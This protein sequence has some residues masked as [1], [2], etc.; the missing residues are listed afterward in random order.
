MP[1]GGATRHS[2]FAGNE[3]GRDVPK[4]RH[5]RKK[6]SILIKK[7]FEASPT[8]WKP[9]FVRL[10]VAWLLSPCLTIAARSSIQWP[11]SNS[12]GVFL[13][14]PSTIT[15]KLVVSTR[16]VIRPTTLSLSRD[17]PEML[18]KRHPLSLERKILSDSDK[19]YVRVDL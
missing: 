9:N 13:T 1:F 14:A 19:P 10:V 16:I 3:A 11:F 18:S 8:L 12:P 17:E 5:V 4:V 2:H 7:A 15:I 6:R